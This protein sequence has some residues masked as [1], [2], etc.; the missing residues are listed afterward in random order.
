MTL[1]HAGDT[2]RSA[3]PTDVE[4][5]SPEWL[6]EMLRANGHDVG[7]T[8]VRSEPVGSGQMAGSFRL[9]PTWTSQGDLPATMVA[10]LATGERPQ[11]EFASGVFRNEVLFYQ[12]LAPTVTA[13]VPH[14]HAAVIS[15]DHTEFVLLLEDMAPSVQGDQIAGCTPEQAHAVALAAARLHAPRW[16]DESLA[17]LPGLYLPTHDDRVLMDSVLEPMA[18]V[19]RSRFALSGREA[20]AID[21][22]VATAGDWLER[23]PRRFAL[24]HGD[25]RVDNILFG[26]DGGVTIVDWQTITLGNPLRDIAFLLSTSLT[27]ED[28]RAH[29]RTIVEA[30]HAALLAQGVTGYCVDD[31]WSDYVDSLI[32]A[33]MIIVLGCGAAMP[34]ERGDRMF[35]AMLQRAAA[36]IDDLNP[37]ALS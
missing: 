7:I 31:C 37:G 27:T 11:R 19:F 3:I 35:M 30:Y 2:G 28:R 25:L 5:L 17:A 24:I 23:P 12:R 4:G 22:L 18:D 10:K 13:P 36:A 8:S 15:D 1:S 33:P 20:A 16:C 14:C 6:S 21:W 29:E 32:Q 26:P 9:T 34:T